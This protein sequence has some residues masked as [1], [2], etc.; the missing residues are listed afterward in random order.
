LKK[1]GKMKKLAR[2]N[3]AENKAWVFAFNYH[4]E[5]HCGPMEADRRAWRD[6]VKEF[7][8]LR[9]FTGALP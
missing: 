2:F 8:R 3:A 7:P 6:M 5:A 1:K 4:L 9:K